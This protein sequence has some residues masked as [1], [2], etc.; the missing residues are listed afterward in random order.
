MEIVRQVGPVCPLLGVCLGH[1]VIGAVYG[2]RVERAPTPM[3]GKTSLIEH[4]SRGVFTNVP[5]PFEA[6]RYH[7]LAVVESTLPA[8][9]EV[10]ARSEDGVVMGLRHLE[11]PV[12]GVQFHPESILTAEGEMILSNFLRVA[13][14]PTA[15]WRA[16]REAG[17]QDGDAGHEGSRQDRSAGHE[18]SRQD[19]SARHE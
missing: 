4:D 1:Q 5:T 19:G 14:H 12:E 10:S 6:G 8:E 17:R 16:R 18:G 11:H 15:G 7:S 2:A 9:L 13:T 3:H